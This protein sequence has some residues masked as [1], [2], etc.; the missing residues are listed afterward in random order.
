MEIPIGKTTPPAAQFV[1]GII[2]LVIVMLLFF[3]VM[4]AA[5]VTYTTAYL[6]FHIAN[7]VFTLFDNLKRPTCPDCGLVLKSHVTY[8]K[9]VCKAK[10]KPKK[11]FFNFF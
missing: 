10:K 5:W 9:H 6:A 8:E 1:S 4:P 11:S 3:G 7:H 2:S